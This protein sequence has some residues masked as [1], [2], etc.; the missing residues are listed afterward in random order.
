MELIMQLEGK[1]RGKNERI[2]E[3]EEEVKDLMLGLLG[4]GYKSKMFWFGVVVGALAE[5]GVVTIVRMVF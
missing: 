2:K 4:E 1:V 3:L 5:F